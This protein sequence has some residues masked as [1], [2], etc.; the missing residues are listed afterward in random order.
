MDRK[1]KTAGRDTAGG[2][3]SAL[4][5]EAARAAAPEAAAAPSRAPS[6]EA[7][8]AAIASER[9][10]LPPRARRTVEGHRVANPSHALNARIYRDVAVFKPVTLSFANLRA[11]SN[12]F[13]S[14]RA[15][16][17][18]I[19][20]DGAGRQQVGLSL[21]CVSDP[22]MYLSQFL[23]NAREIMLQTSQDVREIRVSLYLRTEQGAVLGRV[24]LPPG[25]SVTLQARDDRSTLIGISSFALALD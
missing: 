20:S 3:A 25:A 17:Q 8:R 11:N 6:P 18:A 21:S 13:L 22:V 9:D 24:I 23:V 10:S 4:P 14:L 12:A 16:Q 7:L 15:D 5:V 2:K 1:D 19:W